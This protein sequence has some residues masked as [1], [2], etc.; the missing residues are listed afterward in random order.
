MHTCPTHV[1]RHGHCNDVDEPNVIS[2]SVTSL[3]VVG[4][5]ARRDEAEEHIASGLQAALMSVDQ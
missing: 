3:A 5:P 4:I 2:T 1:T